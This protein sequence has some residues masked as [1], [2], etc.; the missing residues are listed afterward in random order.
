[1]VRSLFV[2]AL[3]AGLG[4]VVLATNIEL[5]PC[6]DKFKPFEY[7]GCFNDGNPPAL[8]FRSGQDQSQMTVEKCTAVCKGT[9]HLYSLTE[10]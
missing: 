2:T 10:G 3:A 8:I 5:P 6:A 1:M 4:H 7:V 9:V